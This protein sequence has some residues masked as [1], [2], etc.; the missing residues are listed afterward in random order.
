M[1]YAELGTF[2]FPYVVVFVIFYLVLIIPQKR[3]EK[4]FREMLD[5]LKVGD[6]IIT[7]G[8]IIGV[9]THIKDNEV[10][11]ET[12][13]EKTKIKIAKWCIKTII[14]KNEK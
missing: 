13:L 8:G 11:V 3:K 5:S 4:K 2:I 6:N 7:I 12:G 14:A 1:D 10:S 9:I